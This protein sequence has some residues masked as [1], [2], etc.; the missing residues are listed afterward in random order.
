MRKYV[1][2]LAVGLIFT[3]MQDA[4][5]EDRFVDGKDGS[6]KDNK[7]GLTW[8]KNANCWGALPWEDASKAVA[9]L[10]SGQKTCE[11]YTDKQSDW[12]LP[13]KDELATLVGND[14]DNGL[15]LPK[16]HPFEKAQ[17][18]HYWSSTDGEQAATAWYIN[19]HNG[20]ADFYGKNTSYYV[21]PVRGQILKP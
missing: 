3:G 6:I 11:G 21:W 8:M 2:I 1:V 7:T 14:S 5:S 9:A 13:S 17:Q 19:M 20:H 12:R 4:L 18:G 16:G 10:D 15:I